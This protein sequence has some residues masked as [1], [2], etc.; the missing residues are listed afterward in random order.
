MAPLPVAASQCGDQPGDA[1]ALAMVRADV[2]NQ[3]DCAT[4]ESHGAYVRCA[5]H[6]ISRAQALDGLSSACVVAAKRCATR[7]TCGRPGRGHVLPH[8]LE[9]Q[10]QVRRQAG[11]QQVQGAVRRLRLH[12]RVHELLRRLRRHRLRAAVHADHYPDP[13]HHATPTIT[14]TPSITPTVTETPT[15]PAICQSNGVAAAAAGAGPVHDSTRLVPMR[16]SGARQPRSGGAVLGRRRG[17][18]VGDHRQPRHRAASTRA[19]CPA[20]GCPTAPRRSSTW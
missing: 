9:R 12:R 14:S 20:C 11:R 3:C 16:R 4:A 6:V 10:D 17:R 5:K 8:H 15:F 7:S 1:I 2:A 13:D 18:R 19:I